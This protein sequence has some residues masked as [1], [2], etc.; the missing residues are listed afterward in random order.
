[1]QLPDLGGEDLLASGNH[2]GKPG[3]LNTQRA[4]LIDGLLLLSQHLRAPCIMLPLSAGPAS[5]N[6][7]RTGWDRHCGDAAGPRLS[8]RS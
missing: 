2:L 6:E 3:F 1:M 5:V 7:K 8:R 4:H